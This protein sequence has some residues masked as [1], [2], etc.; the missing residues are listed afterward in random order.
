MGTDGR[1]CRYV[2]TSKLDD[3]LKTQKSSITEELASSLTASLSHSLSKTL[4]EELTQSLKL[5]FTSLIQETISGLVST[6]NQLESQLE[7]TVTDNA[8]NLKVI[9]LELEEVKKN[10]AELDLA[11]TKLYEEN[12]NILQKLE[13]NISS[14]PVPSN[15]QI[16]ELS[17]RIEERTNRQL[18]QT[19]VFSG[20]PESKQRNGKDESWGQTKSILAN[21]IKN[22]LPDCTYDQAFDMINRAHRSA[23]NVNKQGSRKIYANLN[24]WDDCEEIVN[25]FRFKNFKNSNFNIYVSYKYGPLTSMRRNL[26]LKK[27]GELKK[28]GIIVKGYVKYPAKLMVMYTADG[29][30]EVNEDFSKREVSFQ[31]NVDL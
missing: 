20:I 22:V 21:T 23:P 16:S 29:K 28:D 2:L 9:Q 30:Y 13:E 27:R 15:S 31:E 17:E 12:H 11:V 8:T 24:Y 5:I 7:K 10:N 19:L 3:I 1:E 26:A 18:R 6:V 25:D 14:I 4:I